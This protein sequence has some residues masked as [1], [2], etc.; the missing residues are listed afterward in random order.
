VHVGGPVECPP[1][2]KTLSC[3]GFGCVVHGRHAQAA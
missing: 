1:S 2:V 3:T